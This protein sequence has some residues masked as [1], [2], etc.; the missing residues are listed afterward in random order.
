[1]KTRLRFRVMDQDSCVSMGT[2]AASG[3]GCRLPADSSADSRVS[4]MV[5]EG[6]ADSSAGEGDNEDTTG[7]ATL[8]ISGGVDGYSG[9]MGGAAMEWGGSSAMEMPVETDTDD[10]G[11][12]A[13]TGSGISGGG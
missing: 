10:V 2:T 7:G 5:S 8:A 11:A 12:T 6:A 9:S 3:S 1:M 13:T 4:W